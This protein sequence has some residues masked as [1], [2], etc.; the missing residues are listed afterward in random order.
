VDTTRNVV[1]AVEKRSDDDA[2]IF[3]D[4][5]VAKRRKRKLLSKCQSCR[6]VY[7]RVSIFLGLDTERLDQISVRFLQER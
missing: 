3:V 2:A 4:E 5:E 6:S 1:K 7:S